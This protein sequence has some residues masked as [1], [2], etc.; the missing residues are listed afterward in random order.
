LAAA[1]IRLG[2]RLE[3]IFFVSV[4]QCGF[5]LFA[6]HE[7]LVVDFTFIHH[8]DTGSLAQRAVAPSLSNLISYAGTS[9]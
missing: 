9:M 5:T 3:L 2:E 1:Y 7:L 8:F 6:E 4:F